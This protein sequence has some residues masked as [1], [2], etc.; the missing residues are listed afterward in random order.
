MAKCKSCGK[1]IVVR[2][3][4]IKSNP[5]RV[6]MECHR[7]KWKGRTRHAEGYV[8]VTVEPGRNGRKDLEHRIVMER[9]L[10]RKLRRGEVVHHKNGIRDDNRPENL[11]LCENSG[12]HIA[13]H[14]PEAYANRWNATQHSKKNKGVK[15]AE[16]GEQGGE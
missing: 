16:I 3:H 11:E 7:R 12:V 4:R 9:V 5:N 1:E 8:I 14:H 6:C 13:K 15:N 10:G 2:P